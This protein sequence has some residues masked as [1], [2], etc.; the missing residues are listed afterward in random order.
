MGQRKSM[1]KHRRC[2]TDT[3]ILKLDAYWNLIPY[4]GQAVGFV[5]AKW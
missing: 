5:N 1:C 3:G 2:I 4:L